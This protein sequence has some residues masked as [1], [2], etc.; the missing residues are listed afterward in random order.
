M[1]A[2]LVR[3]LLT[4]IGNYSSSI[5]LLLARSRVTS[6]PTSPAPPTTTIFTGAEYRGRVV[7]SQVL[8]AAIDAQGHTP[9]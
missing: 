6:V 7:F 5:S 2:E 8:R 9:V 3:T 4:Q 1:P